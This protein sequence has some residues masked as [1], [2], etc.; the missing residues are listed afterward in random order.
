[1]QLITEGG[2]AGAGHS[3]GSALH[4]SDDQTTLIAGS[5]GAN[6]GAG[7]VYRHDC[8]PGLCTGQTK[9]VPEAPNLPG[10]AFGAH[11]HQDSMACIM[12]VGAPGTWG[13]VGAVHVW[14]CAGSVCGGW[15]RLDRDGDAARAPGDR[16]GAHV[17]VALD[18]TRL[19]VGAP[20]ALNGT[21]A[22]C[23]SRQVGGGRLCFLSTPSRPP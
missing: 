1:M 19:A 16:Y 9:Y 14:T 18:G 20:G 2:D 3:F 13:G 5:P 4:I 12:A 10:D 23:E 21:G 17:H 6:G 22:V 15:L 7:S 11:V 8:T